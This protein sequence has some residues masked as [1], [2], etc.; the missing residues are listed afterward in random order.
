[1]RILA[2]ITARGGSKRLPGK[3]IRPLGASPLIVWSIDVAK[4]IPEICDILV[5]TD[6][7]AIAEVASNAGAVVP[8]LRP[9]ELATDMAS[10]VDVCLH[11][12]DWYE[13]EN[14][15]V[16]G[17]LLLQPTSPFRSRDTVL[18]GI[19]IFRVHQRRPVLGLSPAES[20]PM[21]CFQLDGET[22]KPFIDSGGLHL[23]SQDLPPAYADNGAFYLIAPEDLRKLRSFYSDDTVP[24]MIDAPEESIDI[25]TE[26][27]W[28]MAEAIL[29]MSGAGQK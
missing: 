22:M 10:S 11:A 24:L 20:H 14:G 16:D 7:S 17:L 3:N 28:R 9:A 23:R 25:D 19:E 21:W 18:R 1:M 27:D 4:G 8:W 15:K 29:A 12:L 26:W 5:S 6:N 13:G 2:L